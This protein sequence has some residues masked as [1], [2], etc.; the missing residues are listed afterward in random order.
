MSADQKYHLKIFS[1]GNL[2]TKFYQKK[3]KKNLETKY[4][5]KQKNKNTKT[6]KKKRVFYQKEEEEEGFVLRNQ[7]RI[8]STY[9]GSVGLSPQ[10]PLSPL[11]LRLVSQKFYE[12]EK[13]NFG[14][15]RVLVSLF[16]CFFFFG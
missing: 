2:E 13:E 3:K 15:C 16:V 8:D 7:D 12:K 5:T 11:S 14:D 6:Q 4:F 10:V 9:F 1:N